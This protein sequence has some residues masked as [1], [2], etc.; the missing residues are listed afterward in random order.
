MSTFYS[1]MAGDVVPDAIAWADPTCTRTIGT[2]STQTLT[3]ITV[4]IT[5]KINHTGDVDITFSR[6]VN[7]GARVAMADGDTFTAN[8]NDTI[9]W[10]SVNSSGAA[11]T[12]YAT[13]KNASNSD[14]VLDAINFVHP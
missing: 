10:R 12:C 9:N 2:S 5:L 3:G 13:L 11:N 7:G 14:A 6:S 4:A 8:N 1:T